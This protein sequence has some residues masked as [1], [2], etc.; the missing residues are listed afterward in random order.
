M[1]M[2]T[3]L[4]VAAASLALAAA[5]SAIIL[6]RHAEATAS[7]TPKGNFSLAAA[8]A[9]S[10]F[11]VY[12]AGD[13]FEELPLVAVQRDVTGFSN[14]VGFIYGTCQPTYDAGCAP[15]LVIQV[16]PACIRNPALYAAAGSMGI[17]SEPA[18]V[19]G[20]PSAYFEDGERLEIQTGVSTIAIFGS[21]KAEVTRAAE[22]L[23]GVNLDAGATEELPQPAP[24]AL[25]GKLRC[26]P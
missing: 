8:R 22:A 2:R 26:G 12:Y 10:D 13:S 21:D 18:T 15:P 14:D 25:T 1:R 20:V 23:K 7:P 16:W 11:P 9:F 24:G 3:K 6:T 4:L 17:P 5:A 19:R